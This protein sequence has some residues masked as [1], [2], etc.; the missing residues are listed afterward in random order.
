M[1]ANVFG[2]LLEDLSHFAPAAAARLDR[3]SI[4]QASIALKGLLTRVEV[5]EDC[6]RLIIRAFALAKF[7]GWDGVGLFRLTEAEMVRATWLHMVV[8]PVSVTRRRRVSW[9]PVQ[10]K[11]ST[12]IPDLRLVRLIREARSAQDLLFSQR[13]KPVVEIARETGRRIGS[14]SRLVRLNYLAPDIVSAIIDGTQPTSLTRRQLIGC[15]LPMDWELQR[16]LLGFPPKCELA[17]LD[18]SHRATAETRL[19]V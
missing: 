17:V 3:L 8:I 19:Q 15:D 4:R 6:V 10:K 5:G 7:I 2:S 1:T 14:F 18:R 16:R 11:R 9:L 13:E 12:S